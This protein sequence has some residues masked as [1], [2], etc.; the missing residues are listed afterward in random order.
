MFFDSLWVFNKNISLKV[1]ELECVRLK[2]SLFNFWI[3]VKIFVLFLDV[4][5]FVYNKI[6][7]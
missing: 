5:I 1:Y 7:L 3:L 2:V 4:E 6:I